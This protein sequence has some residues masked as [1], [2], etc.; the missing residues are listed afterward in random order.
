[1]IQLNTSIHSPLEI[2]VRKRAPNSLGRPRHR[3]PSAG[4]S[5]HRRGHGRK[6]RKKYGRIFDVNSDTL[7][8]GE[9]EALASLMDKA[10]GAASSALD[11][12]P[13]KEVSRCVGAPS[14]TV[15]DKLGKEVRDNRS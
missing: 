8:T 12:P 9:R 13:C 14:Q 1:V 7:E 5:D 2:T 4:D 6:A 11:R 3:S 10:M 15:T